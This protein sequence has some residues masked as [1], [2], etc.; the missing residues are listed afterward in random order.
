MGSNNIEENLF[1]RLSRGR[2][3]WDLARHIEYRNEKDTFFQ[4]SYEN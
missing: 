3:L 1:R 2:I 4:H